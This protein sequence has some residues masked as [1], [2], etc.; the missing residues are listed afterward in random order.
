MH[1]TVSFRLMGHLVCKQTLPFT[2]F[3]KNGLTYLYCTLPMFIKLM[4]DF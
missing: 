3:T 2:L 1:L 4:K